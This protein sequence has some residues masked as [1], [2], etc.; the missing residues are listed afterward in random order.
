VSKTE[1]N[2]EPIFPSSLPSFEKW[3][4]DPTFPDDILINAHKRALQSIERENIISA[5][6]LQDD[7]RYGPSG[8][9]GKHLDAIAMC[10][11]ALEDVDNFRMWMKRVSEVRSRV[12][13][14]Q[15][16]VFS[17]WLSKPTRFPVW[18]WRRVFCEEDAEGDGEDSDS[19]LS[20]CVS[21]GMFE[22][23]GVMD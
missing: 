18:G 19:G 11:G 10:Y 6:A 22:G 1:P 23:V 4:L 16:L 3:C 17:K 15:K 5:A 2:A 8:D 21:M 14:E 20:S 13:P 9:I 7:H 12:K